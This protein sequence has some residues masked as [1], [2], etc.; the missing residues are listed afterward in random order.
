MSCSVPS[1]GWSVNLWPGDLVHA[2]LVQASATVRQPD[3]ITHGG[4]QTDAHTQSP[5]TLL[6]LQVFKELRY[7]PSQRGITAHHTRHQ[8][9]P[10]PGSGLSNKPVPVNLQ[11]RGGQVLDPGTHRGSSQCNYNNEAV[12]RVLWGSYCWNISDILMT[13]SWMGNVK[14]TWL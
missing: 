1:T 8:S 9:Q 10:H 4:R 2:S 14:H 7:R 12:F 6:L 11:L 13:T 3:S 5:T